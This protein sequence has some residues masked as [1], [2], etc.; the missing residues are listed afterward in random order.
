[1]IFIWGLI[2]WSSVAPA[3]WIYVCV[4]VCVCQSRACPCVNV[5]L[6]ESRIPKFRPE[7]QNTLA[8]IP[9]VWRVDLPWPSRSKW[10]QNQNLPHFDLVHTIIHHRWK[11]R[12]PNLDPKCI[13][14]TVKIPNDLG[15]DWHILSFNFIFNLKTYFYY[16]LRHVILCHCMRLVSYLLL[17]REPL[18]GLQVLTFFIIFCGKE[19]DSFKCA[20]LRMSF[21]DT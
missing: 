1:M 21:D 13:L 15:L 5:S 2:F 3:V 9:A 8:E 18:L 19:N 6:G 16:L 17:I 12:F 20:Q 7:V 14:N 4:I 10:T 11:L